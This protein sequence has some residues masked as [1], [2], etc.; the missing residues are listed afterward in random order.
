MMTIKIKK[1][2]PIMVLSALVFAAYIVSSNPPTAK[3][4]RPSATPQLS[5]QVQ[6]L[7]RSDLALTID[8]YGT[9]QPRTQSKL[10]P[11]VS[12]QIISISPKF[13][14]GG[15]FEQ[16]DILVQLDQR[17]LLAEVKISQASL[18]SAK[19]N[20]SEE[21]ARVEQAKQDWQRLGNSEQA[22]DL[23]LR[24]PQLLAAQATVLSAQASLAK[25]KLALER[26]D[27]VAPYTGRIL[28]K[29]VDVGQVVSVGT[30][31]AE[32]YAVDYVEIRLPLKNKDLPYMILP[33]NSRFEDETTQDQPAVTIYSDLATRQSWFGKVVRTEG[34]FDEASQQLFVVAQID[35]PYGKNDSDS[36]P[37]KIGQYVSAKIAGKV[38]KKAL[39]IPN[40]AIYQGSYVYV[41]EDNLLKRKN[42]TIAWQN[43]EVAMIK[44]GVET[45][46]LLV[47]T[48]LG[49]VTSGTIVNVSSI[50]GQDITTQSK[51]KKRMNQSNKA[52]GKNK[53]ADKRKDRV[54]K[55]QGAES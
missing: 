55:T 48:P 43:D 18:F 34:A 27:I 9:I 53:G 14:A 16:G 33:E 24:K 51:P 19:Q 10:L 1:L 6:K 36:M 44:T 31:L 13:R 12:G 40:R 26:S 29:S 41:V 11:Q 17:D 3:R 46:Q 45:N 50:D 54:E 25:A 39:T 42:I 30:E 22:P 37:L 5:V 47:L 21:Q 20:L 28:N 35:D 38:I 8:S 2:L 49:Q 15:F 7:T 23:V 4:G 32:I 52:E